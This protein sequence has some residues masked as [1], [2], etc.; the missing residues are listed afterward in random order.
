MTFKDSENF[1]VVNS[2]AFANANFEIVNI[3]V[4]NSLNS[5]VCNSGQL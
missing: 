2:T 5:T 4:S 3:G 1:N